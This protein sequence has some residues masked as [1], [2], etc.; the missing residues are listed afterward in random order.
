MRSACLASRLRLNTHITHLVTAAAWAFPEVMASS[1]TAAGGGAWKCRVRYSEKGRGG[2]DSR[3][4][5]EG[6]KL[7]YPRPKHPYHE[8][9]I[10]RLYQVKQRRGEERTS[11][12]QHWDDGM[13]GQEEYAEHTAQNMPRRW[14]DVPLSVVDAG[15]LLWLRA[16][17]PRVQGEMPHISRS[18][19]RV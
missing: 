18:G 8:I 19:G 11:C 7:Q 6:K 13:V 2:R 15:R 3:R 14:R 16:S 12:G 10:P 1:A 5:R 17:Q 4:I 9:Q